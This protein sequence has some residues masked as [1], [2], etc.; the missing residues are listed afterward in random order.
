MFQR[1]QSCGFIAC[2][3]GAFVVAI[4]CLIG[5]NRATTGDKIVLRVA[6]WDVASDD[7]ESAKIQRDVFEEFQR[8][9]PEIEIQR[10]GIPGSQEYVK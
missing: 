7:S 1:R 8:L 5:C 4:W 3:L 2:W 9:H 10:E 6:D